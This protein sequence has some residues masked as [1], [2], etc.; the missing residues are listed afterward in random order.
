M[1]LYKRGNTWWFEFNAPD[2]NRVRGS[3]GT[4]DKVLAQEFFAHHQVTLWRQYRLGEK[5]RRTWN[6]AVVRWLKE[7]SH[8]ATIETDKIHLRWLDRFLG[9][10]CL[11]AISREVIDK[12]TDAKLAEDVANG[13]VNRVLEVVRAILRRSRDDWEWI[14]RIPKLRMLS[15]PTRRIRWLTREEA[16]TLLAELPLHLRDMAALSLVTGLRRANVT[17]LQ[18]SQ[19]D[20]VR[21]CAWI[22]PDQA[23]ARRAIP[24]ALNVEAMEVITRHQ[25]VHNTYVFSYRGKK[26]TQVNTKAWQNALKRCGIENFRW[27]DLRHT[28]ASWLAQEGTPLHVLQEMGGWESVEMVRRYAHLSSEHLAPYADR[29]GGL[30]LVD[31]GA[32]P[33]KVP[34]GAQNEKTLAFAKALM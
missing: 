32:V 7:Q 23:K 34:T 8:K 6:E 33:T 24:V 2:G 26:I 19:I 14:D 25:G 27:H 31:V 16:R 29:L 22:H 13:T 9:G 17:G 4:S 12:I 10:K 28:W 30:R 5:P 15:E 20:L 3:T 1:S 21:R 18:W 11:D